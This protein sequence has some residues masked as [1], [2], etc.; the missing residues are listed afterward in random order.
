MDILGITSVP[1]ITIICYLIGAAL[2]AWDKFDDRKIP[3]IMGI[4]GAV[5]GA[6][7]FYV[8]P[9]MVVGDDIITAIAVGIVSGFAA[10]GINQIFK[11]LK[12][13]EGE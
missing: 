3:V 9:K 8:V 12:K 6:V 4:A 10:T 2:K 13:S 1:A 11:Q 7:S 5:L